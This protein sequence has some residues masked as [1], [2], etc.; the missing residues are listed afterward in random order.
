MQSRL[1]H[2]GEQRV[3]QMKSEREKEDLGDEAHGG[4]QDATHFQNRPKEENRDRRPRRMPSA[5]PHQ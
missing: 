4:G 3:D 1:K 2:S 5:S